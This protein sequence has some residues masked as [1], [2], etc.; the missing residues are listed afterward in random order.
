MDHHG[1][2]DSENE[3]EDGGDPA[4]VLFFPCPYRR[5]SELENVQK[6]ILVLED[7]VPK[8]PDDEDDEE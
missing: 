1:N 5:D 6:K 7:N 4:H 2:N 3:E 8:V